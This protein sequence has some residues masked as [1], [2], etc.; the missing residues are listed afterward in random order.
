MHR[1]KEYNAANGFYILWKLSDTWG[2]R[3]KMKWFGSQPLLAHRWVS[4]YC[5]RRILKNEEGLTMRRKITKMSLAL[6]L[7]FVML[8]S[9]NAQQNWTYDG[10]SNEE[11]VFDAPEPLLGEEFFQNFSI[12]S[13]ILNNLQDSLPLSRTGELIIP[14]QFG[15]F[16]FDDNGKLVILV[17]EQYMETYSTENILTPMNATIDTSAS[18]I[19]DILSLVRNESVVSVRIVKNS[20]NSLHDV[21]DEI[22]LNI[23]TSTIRSS[24]RFW[25]LG[26][27]ENKVLVYLYDFNDLVIN[28]F[29]EEI[30]DSPA[31]KFVEVSRGVYESENY[32]AMNVEE[33][34]EEL[35]ILPASLNDVLRPGS[36]IIASWQTHMR[37][38]GSIGYRARRWDPQAGRYVSGFVTAMHV[39]RREGQYIVDGIEVH[40]Y[41]PTSSTTG[42]HGVIWGRVFGRSFERDAAFV[43]LTNEA[44]T[45]SN[46]FLLP[47][48]PRRHIN[49]SATTA[50]TTGRPP[51][52][53][54][55]VM[56]N[57]A[58]SLNYGRRGVMEGRITYPRL[59][60]YVEE[61]WVQDYVIR[62]GLVGTNLAPEW[63]GHPPR[64][65]IGD[66]GGLVIVPI[67]DSGGTVIGGNVAG[68]LIGFDGH[69][70]VYMRA[71]LINSALD[72][73]MF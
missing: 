29:R 43:R 63:G 61:F 64:G 45:L 28:T 9:V 6:I 69:I 3:A 7:S 39:V 20:Y 8:L 65:E 42:R 34:N 67:A 35:E 19:L 58:F 14:E 41:I 25:A 21:M 53:G 70:T 4:R 40:Q 44:R 38:F 26:T 62:S 54:Q 30:S 32:D 73:T 18:E 46:E 47:G 10:L 50:H 27:I 17:V 36:H 12:S 1:F 48:M 56:A 68:I 55:P 71:E 24:I 31:I 52:A 66:S 33:D 13:E 51:Q 16:Y 5:S 23:G 60:I 72:L 2:G 57:G 11:F 15:G 22:G 49:Y 37:Y 59:E